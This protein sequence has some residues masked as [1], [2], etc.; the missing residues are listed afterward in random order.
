MSDKRSKTQP[1]FYVP[2]L[3]AGLAFLLFIFAAPAL[4]ADFL[5]LK[6][7]P[8]HDALLAGDQVSAED[9]TAFIQSRERA[10]LWHP[11]NT[12]YD[13]LAMGML[14]RTRRSG[15]PST[16]ILTPELEQVIAWQ[17]SALRLSPADTYG[18]SRLAYV[19][20]LTEGLSPA[21]A[22]ALTYSIEA[23]PYEPRLMI[24][25]INMASL[26]GNK[27]ASDVREQIP[28]MIRDAWQLFPKELAQSAQQGHFSASVEAVLKDSPA[29]LA[30]WK[31]LT[32]G[33]SP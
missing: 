2:L 23:A 11:S 25:R 6:G 18:W 21:A 3:L 33:T 16:P 22:E 12:T 29:D 7:N 13:D 10:A 32:S 4:I 19:R 9:L 1:L 24:T 27:L 31:R 20:I 28:Q 17:T 5:L 26:L 14:E 8:I 30:Q 15:F